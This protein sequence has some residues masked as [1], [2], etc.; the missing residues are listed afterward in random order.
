M[1]IIFAAVLLSMVISVGGVRNS[2]AADQ[3]SFAGEWDFK[4]TWGGEPRCGSPTTKTS[5]VVGT[6]GQISGRFK[7]PVAGQF[8][9]DGA[10]LESGVVENLVAKSDSGSVAK[11][12]GEFL[13]TN[14]KGRHRSLIVVSGIDLKCKGKWT[15]TRR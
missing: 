14:A 9:V 11:F 12:T 10:V 8:V 2:A 1:K 4:V 7:V 3:S 6:Q 13:K 5:L 15:A